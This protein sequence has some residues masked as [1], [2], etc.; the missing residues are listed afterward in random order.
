MTQL[1]NLFKLQE[2]HD[3]MDKIN[4]QLLQLKNG[5]QNRKEVEKY[6]QLS[7]QLSK[8]E[9]SLNS[10]KV[11]LRQSD[12]TLKE[13]ELKLKDLDD[14][15]YSGSITN[16]KQLNHL[17]GERDRISNLLE[18]LETEV[19]ENMDIINDIE[20]EIKSIKDKVV[21]FKNQIDHNK[22]E[23]NNNIKKLEKSKVQLNEN[24]SSLLNTIDDHIIEKYNKIQS[25]KGPALAIVKDGICTGCNIIVPNYQIEDMDKDKIIQCE[26]CNRILYIPNNDIE[27]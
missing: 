21:D 22:E 12:Y 3:L 17:T 2:N 4:K 18:E 9:E 11:K 26:S 6:Q 25:R 5:L 8:M 16:E 20:I 23:S 7:K 24:I 10:G 19:L 14:E 13:Y 1:E 15:L 27:K